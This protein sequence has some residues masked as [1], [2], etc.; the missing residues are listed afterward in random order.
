MPGVGEK[1]AKKIDEILA[2]GQLEKLKKIRN[3][4]SSTAVN[5]LC[6]VFGIGMHEF[7]SEKGEMFLGQE[8]ANGTGK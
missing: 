6:R 3:D 2:T 7:Q 8:K 1:I 5:L 4:D